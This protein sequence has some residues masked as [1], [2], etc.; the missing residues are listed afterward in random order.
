MLGELNA[1][2]DRAQRVVVIAS[3]EHVYVFLFSPLDHRSFRTPCLVIILEGK[4]TATC[5][6]TDA[7]THDDDWN[8]KPVDSY[9]RR[10]RRI[11]L[12]SLRRFISDGER[13][14]PTAYTHTADIARC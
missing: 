11:N 10:D 12:C 4:N 3:S 13:Q 8:T 9:A 5:K 7:A 1:C 14:Q 6:L 2:A